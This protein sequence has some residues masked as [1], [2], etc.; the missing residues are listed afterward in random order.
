M[1]ANLELSSEVHPGSE[2]QFK[3]YLNIQEISSVFMIKFA[4]NNIKGATYKF[5]CT[6]LLVCLTILW[7][8]YLQ[9]DLPTHVTYALLMFHTPA[10]LANIL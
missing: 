3:N 1:L 4:S 2:F 8:I 9:R 6:V 10:N 5:L 7:H